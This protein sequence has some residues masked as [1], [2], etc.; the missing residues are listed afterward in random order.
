MRVSSNLTFRKRIPATVILILNLVS[1]GCINISPKSNSQNP[2]RRVQT[3]MHYP[4]ILYITLSNTPTQ[5][6][7][8]YS[9]EETIIT[10]NLQKYA[11]QA[12]VFNKHYAN[13]RWPF[14][15]NA[16]LLTGLKPIDHGLFMNAFHLSYYYPDLNFKADQLPK[17]TP[18]IAEKLAL[19]GYQT[20]TWAGEPHPSFFSSDS[21]LKRGFQHI[22]NKSIRT[23]TDSHEIADWM[24]KHH[25]KAPMF[26]HVAG[27]NTH[28]PHYFV[29][30]IPERKSH[31]FLKASKSYPQNELQFKNIL[32]A[33]QSGIQERCPIPLANLYSSKTPDGQ[34][35]INSFRLSHF[36]INRDP[37]QSHLEY[38]DV[39]K[40]ALNY[41][42]FILAPLLALLESIPNLVV[43]ISSDVG[44]ITPSD[45]PQNITDFT[46]EFCHGYSQ[47]LPKV[48]HIPLI[49]LLPKEK[50]NSLQHI[51]FL[52]SQ[53]QVGNL[54]ELIAENFPTISAETII[55]VMKA[56]PYVEAIQFRPH[57]GFEKVIIS[58]ENTF[59]IND[60]QKHLSVKLK[61]GD[62]ELLA[63]DT[64]KNTIELA[65]LAAI[66]PKQKKADEVFL[67]SKYSA[68]KRQ[69]SK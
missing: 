26:V 19:R 23:L 1:G 57:F 33:C 65:E 45:C 27:M 69:L 52:T 22:K 61:E 32:D 31:L 17:Q 58:S 39:I 55:Q 35:G 38:S 46:K 44:H 47:A 30:E 14:T 21:G 40:N 4:H 13:S 51:N 67:S 64:Q 10:P 56:Q 48:F 8:L 5:W 24:V 42:D 28:F 15:A 41:Q 59:Q 50:L 25:Q 18:T 7:S 49:V 20:A 34:F 2:L 62:I 43:I 12:L 63:R 11:N 9:K 53:H 54:L 68:K 60:T 6:L 37:P 3:P 36:F 29:P 16:T 66:F